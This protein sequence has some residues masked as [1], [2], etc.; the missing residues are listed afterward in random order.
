M[1]ESSSLDANLIPSEER[2]EGKLGKST[3]DYHEV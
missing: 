1:G 3:L 2:Q